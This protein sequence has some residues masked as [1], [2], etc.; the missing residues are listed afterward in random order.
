ME[1]VADSD[2]DWRASLRE[3][4]HLD[5][6]VYRDSRMCERLQQLGP[7]AVPL[8]DLC[9]EFRTSEIE[10]ARQLLRLGAAEIVQR[11]GCDP[12]GPRLSH[13]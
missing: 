2:Y 8:D 9:D 12:H 7:E 11:L 5:R 4:A 10:T 6:S 1:L 3:L 13:C